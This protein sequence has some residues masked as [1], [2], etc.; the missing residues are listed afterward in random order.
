[1]A[2]EITTT[3]HNDITNAS[4]TAPFIIRALSEKPGFWRFAKEFNLTANWAS[5]A[6]S[7]PVENSFW[8]TPAD[9]GAGVD[10]EFDATQGT[11]LGN[12][13]VTTGAV[14]CTPGEYGV[15]L[16]VTDNVREDSVSAIDLFGLLEERMLHVISLAMTDDFLALLVS[17]SNSVGTSGVDLS[18]AQ[19]IAAQQGLRT[20]GADADALVYILDNQQ[21]LDVETGLSA[22]NAAAAVFA[23]SADRLINYAPTA[24]NGMGSSRQIMT[25]RNVPVFATGLT[26]TANAAADVVGACF[27]PATNYND[28]T[29]STTFGMAWKRLPM[30]ETDRI[31]IGRSTQLVMTARAG[32]VEMQNDSG[33]AIVTDA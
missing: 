20:R 22:G 9:D 8:G 26:D 13:T 7:I 28:S 15:A 29:G 11:D 5:P 6:L 16:E 14:T 33:T 4:L 17:L 23:L 1:M 18:V 32:F 3:S 2:N 30:L 21:A 12:T 19:M 10:T 24:D 31:I 27:C 25:F